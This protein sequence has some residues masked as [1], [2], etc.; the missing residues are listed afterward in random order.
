[1]KRDPSKCRIALRGVKQLSTQPFFA[2]S[3]SQECVFWISCSI[4]VS[5]L[6]ISLFVMFGQWVGMYPD[7]SAW[8]I[9]TRWKGDGTPWAVQ[10]GADDSST[11][12]LTA[13]CVTQLK[14][15]NKS[16]SA[17]VWIK[18]WAPPKMTNNSNRKK[19]SNIVIQ[20][21]TIGHKFLLHLRIKHE[22]LVMKADNVS[23]CK[24]MLCSL[25]NGYQISGTTVVKHFTAATSAL[26]CPS[27]LLVQ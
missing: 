3:M 6:S 1:M 2:I 16:M 13:L 11:L 9:I 25:N 10:Q 15:G 27:W 24:S 19:K 4:P 12:F 14:G 26:W 20:K 18:L 8:D 23:R 17:S 7:V 5:F 22:S 21:H